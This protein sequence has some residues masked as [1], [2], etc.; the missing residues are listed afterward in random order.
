LLVQRLD[1]VDFLRA[2][3]DIFTVELVEECDAVVELGLI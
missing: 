2:G 3:M 1:I